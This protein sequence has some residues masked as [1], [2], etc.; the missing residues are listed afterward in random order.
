[1]CHFPDRA[2]KMLA[3]LETN[4]R[5]NPE[6]AEAAFAYGYLRFLLNSKSKDTVIGMRNFEMVFDNFN[7]VL[8]L[9]PDYWLALMFKVILLLSLPEIMRD[10]KELIKS[11]EMMMNQQNEADR[12]EPYF[13]I[14][15]II[16]ADYKYLCADREGAIMVLG[17]GMKIAPQTP[18]PYPSFWDYFAMPFK[19][20][21]KR[22]VR[23]NEF[24]MALQ[25][26]SLGKL[27]FPTD[28]E[29]KTDIRQGW[30]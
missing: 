11:I 1:M 24:D 2:E 13:I 3:G 19:D 28:K 14:P 5:K 20:Y 4:A 15:Y 6:N 8:K 30:L 9:K 7:Q 27:Y 16:L 10:D 29:F 21:M 12:K 17:E 22:L 26:Q 25:V 23:S 18:M